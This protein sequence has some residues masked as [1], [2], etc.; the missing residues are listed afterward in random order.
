M[1]AVWFGV[2]AILTIAMLGIFIFAVQ[3]VFH[4]DDRF[5]LIWLACIIVIEG[6]QDFQRR[7]KP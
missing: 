1:K 6:G 7:M 3:T 2:G 5:Y 4:P